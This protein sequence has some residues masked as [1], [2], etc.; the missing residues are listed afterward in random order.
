MSDDEQV[1]LVD[2]GQ[3]RLA[4]EQAIQLQ[5]L[6]VH[7]ASCGSCILALLDDDLLRRAESVF[8]TY[9]A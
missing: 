5:V 8:K 9:K 7:L 4:R 2:F 6:A 1:L 3:R